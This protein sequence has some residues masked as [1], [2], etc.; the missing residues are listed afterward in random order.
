MIHKA[1]HRQLVIDPDVN[2][3]RE[4]D[5]WLEAINLVVAGMIKHAEIVSQE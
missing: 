4:H 3:W 5:T 1:L 2:H